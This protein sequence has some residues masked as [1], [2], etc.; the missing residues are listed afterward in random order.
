MVWKV[1]GGCEGTGACSWRGCSILAA[2]N[3]KCHGAHVQHSALLQAPCPHGIRRR[4]ARILLSPSV[5]SM[6]PEPRPKR[7]R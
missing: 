2:P 3:G 4:K 1:Q 6:S 7:Y 5:S